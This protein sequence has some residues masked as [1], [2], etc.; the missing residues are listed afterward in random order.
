MR[1]VIYGVILRMLMLATVKGN[2]YSHLLLMNMTKKWL[3]KY[4]NISDQCITYIE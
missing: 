4:E 3:T 1:G 2:Y